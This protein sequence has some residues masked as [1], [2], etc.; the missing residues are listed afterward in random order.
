MLF[1]SYA[2]DQL[3]SYDAAAKCYRRAVTSGDHENIVLHKL[4]ELYKIMQQYDAAF[5]CYKQN[6]EYNDQQNAS[7][8]DAIDALTYM[9]EY[10]VKKKKY[11][12]A[13]LYAMRLQDF[14][15]PAKDK[16]RQIMDQVKEKRLEITAEP[17]VTRP[18]E[19]S[20]PTAPP[21]T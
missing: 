9:A 10:C 14:G 6:L 20:Q 2:H 16:G 4:A 21:P 15:G 13:E 18:P 17:T 19:T 8:Q 11:E 7:G 3:K 1:R 5:S 12:E